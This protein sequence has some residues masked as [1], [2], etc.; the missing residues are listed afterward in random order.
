MAGAVEGIYQEFIWPRVEGHELAKG[1]VT[2][3]HHARMPIVL[4]VMETWKIGIF[5]DSP[6]SIFLHLLDLV[7]LWSGFVVLITSRQQRTQKEEK[8]PLG[9]F[10][11]ALPN[12][13]F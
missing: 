12:C 5:R 13:G 9:L 2:C 8:V 10:W 4:G 1:S 3:Q 7:I 11:R 6:N